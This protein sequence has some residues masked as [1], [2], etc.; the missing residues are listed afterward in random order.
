V[1]S[2]TEW[3]NDGNL[4]WCIIEVI[5]C[6]PYC[7]FLSRS[8][9]VQ[10]N[11]SFLIAMFAEPFGCNLPLIG[12]HVLGKAVIHRAKM[13][14]LRLLFAGTCSWTRRGSLAFECS[15]VCAVPKL[16]AV[17]DDLQRRSQGAPAMI[18]RASSLQSLG[19]HNLL[20]FKSVVE[21]DGCSDEHLWAR[22]YLLRSSRWTIN[23]RSRSQLRSG[24]IF[25]HLTSVVWHSHLTRGKKEFEDSR[26]H[27]KLMLT[28]L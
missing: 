2:S 3:R 11:I 1:A 13:R 7:L 20:P 4:L 8:L 23:P 9:S 17:R 27:A 5:S 21:S 14:K 6:K 16:N 26:L 22:C 19:E 24:Q 28:L 25:V 10:S 12:N 15:S 18:S